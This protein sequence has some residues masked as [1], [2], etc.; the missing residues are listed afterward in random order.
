L[1][2]IKNWD[3]FAGMHEKHEQPRFKEYLPDRD[4]RD[5]RK[6]TKPWRKPSNRAKST[7]P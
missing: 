7:R 1:S 4:Y 5:R 3:N 6:K 2:K